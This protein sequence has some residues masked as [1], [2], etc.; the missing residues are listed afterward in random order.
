MRIQAAVPSS[1]QLHSTYKVQL[2]KRLVPMYPALHST[3][4]THGMHAC[5]MRSCADGLNSMIAKSTLFEASPGQRHHHKLAMRH[6]LRRL[7][8]HR[9]VQVQKQSDQPGRAPPS[10]A[11]DPP[12]VVVTTMQGAPRPPST[13]TCC[14]L[15]SPPQGKGAATITN[16]NNCR[17]AERLRTDMDASRHP[18][19]SADLDQI[20][21]NILTVLPATTLHSASVALRCCSGILG[22][23]Q[24]PR[25][26]H[27][28]TCTTKTKPHNFK[29]YKDTIAHLLDRCSR[30]HST[31]ANLTTHVPAIQATFHSRLLCSSLSRSH[32]QHSV[33]LG[34]TRGGP[35]SPE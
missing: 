4:H 15:N 13:A 24:T 29:P 12:T 11:R 9:R 18:L 3:L 30:L 33:W 8:R 31:M 16:N 26:G 7:T 2:A 32:V 10:Q 6:N 20:K 22:T 28:T 14:L 35:T 19:C 25:M 17:R 5:D 1:T 21:Q 27:T 34:A 23:T